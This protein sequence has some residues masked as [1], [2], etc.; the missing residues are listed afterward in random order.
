MLRSVAGPPLLEPSAQ[1]GGGLPGA[2]SG[3]VLSRMSMAQLVD[4]LEALG[5]QGMGGCQVVADAV[6]RRYDENGGRISRRNTARSLKALA[7]V[8]EKPAELLAVLAGEL[9]GWEEQDPQ[10]EDLR[11][12]PALVALW[13]LAA[14]DLLPANQ[15]TVEY[16]LAFL[17]SEGV[18]SSLLDSKHDACLFVQSLCAVQQ[19]LPE[20]ASRH[21][22]LLESWGSP[23]GDEALTGA[24][25]SLDFNDAGMPLQLPAGGGGGDWPPEL[26]GPSPGGHGGA[27]PTEAPSGAQPAWSLAAPP[28]GLHLEACDDELPAGFSAPG[29]SVR[30]VFQEMQLFWEMEQRK[31]AV[32]SKAQQVLGEVLAALNTSSVLKS[33]P[34]PQG[35][36]AAEATRM[37]GG[38]ELQ[39][40]SGPYTVDWGNPFLRIGVLVLGPGDF[41][42]RTDGQEVLRARARM[43]VSHLRQ[44]WRLV[45]LRADAIQE[46][47]GEDTVD[48]LFTE[49]LRA[50]VMRANSAEPLDTRKALKELQ[51]LQASEPRRGS[52]AALSAR[53]HRHLQR[54]LRVVFPDAEVRQVPD[55][56]V[57]P[58][59]APGPRQGGRP[60]R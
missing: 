11:T 21:I 14:L 29:P 7:E 51:R 4:V 2:S 38:F 1:L 31:A 36:L 12:R 3:S 40:A 56:E 6:A 30:S 13:S 33:A 34:H 46:A 35:A 24:E 44:D 10:A 32:L 45:L 9:R 5:E 19:A 16:L 25:E 22:Q 28:A 57:R 60:S 27:M 26:A 47:L 17:G 59:P 58:E 20:L 48:E 15:S 42:Q 55:A 53:L 43:R 18:S 37:T 39:W 50:Y 8:G 52:P 41:V 23:L 54:L 49:P